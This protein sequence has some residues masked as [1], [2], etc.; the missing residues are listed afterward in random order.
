MPSERNQAA[1]H[2][3]GYGTAAFATHVIVAFL[4]ES[5]A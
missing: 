3:D 4:V 1:P 2:R 5:I